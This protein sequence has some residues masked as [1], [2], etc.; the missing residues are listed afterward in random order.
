MSQIGRLA[1]ATLRFVAALVIGV[2]LVVVAQ[3]SLLFFGE[4]QRFSGLV[5]LFG[6]MAAVALALR[7]AIS[8]KL[9]RF[10]RVA[11]SAAT[12]I[13]AGGLFALVTMAG[14]AVVALAALSALFMIGGGAD[15]AKNY[16]GPMMGHASI[17]LW[18][19]LLAIA[20][21]GYAVFRVWRKT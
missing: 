20:G 5:L 16:F 19:A 13:T 17:A 6:T 14:L 18:L 11:A 15:T 12:A 9:T 21:L 7:Y 2:G 4:A 1:W 3:F 8:G 10:D